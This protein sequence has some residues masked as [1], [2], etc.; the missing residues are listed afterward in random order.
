[1]EKQNPLEILEAAHDLRSVGPPIPIAR[2]LR[3]CVTAEKAFQ[4]Y[5]AQR[6]AANSPESYYGAAVEFVES[7]SG[8]FAALA[9]PTVS[10]MVRVIQATARDTGAEWARKLYKR[11][12]AALAQRRGKGRA[13][14]PY[15]VLMLEL[16]AEDRRNLEDAIRRARK[17]CRGKG[18]GSSVRVLENLRADGFQIKHR[19][20]V[21][22]LPPG[23]RTDAA[24]T[25]EL[26]PRLAELVV[27]DQ[28]AKEL[29]R[30]WSDELWAS[31]K[32]LNGMYWEAEDPDR[33]LR[34]LRRRTK[35]RR[36]KAA[37]RV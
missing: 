6:P 1:L 7:R 30:E 13:L 4:R 20:P 19:Q 18:K 10:G 29:A 9:S 3:E 2:H 16:K 14:W 12:L 23:Y 33:Q 27:R 28:P 25:A 31:R 17:Q 37:S 32:D 21:A 24:R 36:A 22:A 5:I 11:F 15:Q 26:L 8:D 34:D 35:T